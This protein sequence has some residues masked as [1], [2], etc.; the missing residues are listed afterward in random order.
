MVAPGSYTLQLTARSAAGTTVLRRAIV[1][2]AFTIVPSA[3]RLRPGRTLTISIRSS[4]ALSSRPV[5]T[6]DQASRPP[7][8]AFATP[9]GAGRYVARF[10]V[11]AGGSGTAT[12]RV[13]AR[14]AAGRKNASGRAVSVV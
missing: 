7:V 12:I 6:F 9:L 8:R 3:T 13:S 14:D 1:V 4:E 10:R 5:V 11:A 2:D